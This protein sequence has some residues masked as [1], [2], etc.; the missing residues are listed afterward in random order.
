M[1]TSHLY[2]LVYT[3]K[4]VIKIGKAN[5]VVA[6]ITSLK[7]HWGEPDYKNSYS[8][9]IDADLVFK[10]EK[11]LH[12]F[13]AEHAAGL[14]EGDGKTEFFAI[15]CLDQVLEYLEVFTKRSDYH[16]LKKGIKA[17]EM[18]ASKK[19]K[20]TKLR[21]YTIKQERLSKIINDAAK[22]LDFLL[23]IVGILQKYREQIKY[24]YK[25]DGNYLIFTLEDKRLADLASKNKQEIVDL[26]FMENGD[27]NNYSGE[28]I[29]LFSGSKPQQD[30]QLREFS[31][32]IHN[33]V[34]SDSGLLLEFLTK[35]YRQILLSLPEQSPAY[36]RTLSSN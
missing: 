20:D 22:N 16:V 5:D 29:N 8:L 12:L 23:R 9:E 31:I 15:E 25:I 1:Q 6:R 11:A 4:N 28:S 18:D 7:K 32:R 34:D 24:H 30:Q 26:F 36:I 14:S 33:C 2:I 3:Q 21:K 13:L 27:F 10:I 19:L 35:Q 17:P